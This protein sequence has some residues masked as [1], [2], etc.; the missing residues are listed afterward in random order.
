MLDFMRRN[1]ASVFIKILFVLLI[2]SFGI[3]GIADYMLKGST[4][5]IAKIGKTKIE[6][7]QFRG[8]LNKTIKRFEGVREQLGKNADIFTDQLIAEGVLDE[9]INRIL[10]QKY[11]QDVGL[12]VHAETLKERIRTL[13]DFKGPMGNFDVTRYQEAIGRYAGSEKR[14]IQSLRQDIITKQIDRALDVSPAPPEMMIALLSKYKKQKRQADLLFIPSKKKTLAEPTKK[15][16]KEFYRKNPQFFLTNE[17]KDMSFLHIKLSKEQKKELLSDIALQKMYT[18]K[19]DLL[20]TPETRQIEQAILETKEAAESVYQKAIAGTSFSKA[21]AESG[22]K[23]IKMGFMKKEDLSSP[24]DKHAFSVKKGEYINPQETAFGWHVL[25]VKNIKPASRPAF[26][27]IKPSL[28]A[29]LKE[30]MK[31]EALI[32]LS[33]EVDESLSSGEELAE[34]A[35]QYELNLYSLKDFEQKQ[36]ISKKQ[37]PALIA[38]NKEVR[39][40]LSE[41]KEDDFS[42]L[43]ELKDGSYAV[44]SVNLVTPPEPKPFKVV[45]EKALNIFTLERANTETKKWAEA[46]KEA[47]ITTEDLTD[48]ARANTLRLQSTTPFTRDGTGAW[49]MTKELA[50]KI[51]TLT[52]G[53]RSIAPIYSGD[54]FAG[55]RKAEKKDLP[56]GYLLMRLKKIIPFQ[57]TITAKEKQEVRQNLERN[58]KAEARDRFFMGLRK[59]FNVKID[60]E[61]FAKTLEN[62]GL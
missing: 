57:G 37:L 49:Q 23:I 52:E 55:G 58:F 1:M 50:E 4:P 12:G 3:W 5:S 48:F 39:L 17:K 46:Q 9:M 62:R 41:L 47:L 16:V 42:P 51:F 20:Q 10:V 28:K 21:A 61:T 15:E 27:K 8:E 33:N 24:L 2:L 35:E 29:Q 53:E 11:A 19:E 56:V 38:K 7:E 14:M 31:V 30:E 36:V 45:K 32:N 18:E 54:P 60:E 26:N 22:Q 59:K 34:I 43:I 25:Y 6:K 13:P 40:N 44:I